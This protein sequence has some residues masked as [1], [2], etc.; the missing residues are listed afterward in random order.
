[1]WQHLLRILLNTYGKIRDH[2]DAREDIKKIGIMQEL[3]LDDL[4]KG[5]ELPTSCITFSKHENKDF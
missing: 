3:W 2:G 5:T 1:M 4:V